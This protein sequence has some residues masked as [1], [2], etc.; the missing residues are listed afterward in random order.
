MKKDRQVELQYAIRVLQSALRQRYQPCTPGEYY[1]SINI[2]IEKIEL[3][4]SHAGIAAATH[5]DVVAE[6]L[7]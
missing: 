1:P 4:D 6:L 2:G 5:D 3:L 7:S